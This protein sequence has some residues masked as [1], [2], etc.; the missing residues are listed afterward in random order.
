MICICGTYVEEDS[1]DPANRVPC[2]ECGSTKRV[3]SGCGNLQGVAPQTKDSDVCTSGAYLNGA[4]DILNAVDV[5]AKM[6][7]KPLIAIG[8][9][10]AHCLELIL[11]A[12]L[13]CKGVDEPGLKKVRHDLEEAW[14]KAAELGLR[15]EKP[16]PRW[17]TVLNA[18][19]DKPYLFRYPRNS[20]FLTLPHVPTLLDN[21]RT[22]LGSVTDDISTRLD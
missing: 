20:S 18:A 15:V 2:P 12:Y 1:D 4:T 6:K 11:K 9:L 17:C 19:H 21:L 5:L 7:P 13:I 8:I 3:I 14:S 22:V 10:S 16:P